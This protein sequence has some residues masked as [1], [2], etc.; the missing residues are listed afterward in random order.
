M[1]WVPVA[2]HLIALTLGTSDCRAARGEAGCTMRRVQKSTREVKKD[3][4]RGGVKLPRVWSNG[5]LCEHPDGQGHG[6]KGLEFPSG[7]SDANAH[8][9]RRDSKHAFRSA[10]RRGSW[11]LRHMRVTS[12]ARIGS[13]TPSAPKKRLQRPYNLVAVVLF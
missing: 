4:K 12:P 9:Q 1:P 2:N 11:I 7:R 13:G 5:S 8:Q 10:S 6:R 3:F